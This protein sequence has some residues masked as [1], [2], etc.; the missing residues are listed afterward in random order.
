[1]STDL[2]FFKEIFKDKRSHISIG[3]IKQMSLAADRSFL[4]CLVSIFPEQREVIARMTF[5]LAGPDS[6]IAELPAIDDMV[7]VAFADGDNDYAFII[8]RLTSV[9]D[10]IPLNSANGDFV[11]K[12]KAG[13]KAWLTSNTRINL[14]KG[15]TE[16][17]ENMVLGQELKTLLIST[18]D[19]LKMLNTKLNSLA[20]K[21]STHTHSGN[22]GYPTSPPNQASDFATLAADF[23]AIGNDF[24]ALNT[25]PVKDQKIL[26]N[27]SFTEKGT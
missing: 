3:K 26:S 20:L 15:D 7:L 2:E 22:L 27:I 10:K 1:M 14:S 13:K 25:S 8:T 23:T 21:D 16:P 9:E 4:K 12:A 18:Y 24:D 5:S 6:G 11:I 17:T 19:K